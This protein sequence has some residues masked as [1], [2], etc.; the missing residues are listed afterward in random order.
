MLG[1]KATTTTSDDSAAAIGRG[2]GA[3][4]TIKLPT[5]ATELSTT[6]HVGRGQRKK[7]VTFGSERFFLLNKKINEYNL[8]E[9]QPLRCHKP[10]ARTQ[11]RRLCIR[12]HDQVLVIWTKNVV[13]LGKHLF[14]H[15][16][17]RYD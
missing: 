10:L 4:A 9:F 11:V 1:T 7:S 17:Y 16:K 13:M 14:E 6:A 2:R 12:N 15:G 3:G 5:D 8:L